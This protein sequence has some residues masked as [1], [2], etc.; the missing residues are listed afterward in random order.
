MS[1]I[2]WILF[3]ALL[4]I[5]GVLMLNKQA[6]PSLPAPTQQYLPAAPMQA[7]AQQAPSKPVSG[8]NK[9][10]NLTSAQEVKEFLIQGGL[11]MVFAEWC[12][13]CKNMMPAL[14]EASNMPNT[15]IGKFDGT[16]DQKF[17]Q[18]QGIRGF[19]TVLLKGSG[20]GEFPKY[21]G[22]RDKDSLALAGRVG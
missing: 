14:E 15:R 10:V 11:V 5:L 12:G 7:Q 16:K 2:V 20:E 3:G 6:P 17:M 4:A 8:P 1:F 19:P 21:N 22:Q 9:V 13:H 18:E